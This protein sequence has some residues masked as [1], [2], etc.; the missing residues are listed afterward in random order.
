MYI[1]EN[2]LFSFWTC[3]PKEVL[4]LFHAVPYVLLP[5][6]LSSSLSVSVFTNELSDKKRLLS[7]LL[8][9]YSL[10]LQTL[11]AQWATQCYGN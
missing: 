10:L 3:V 5:T 2:S 7:Q 9:L 11:S 6:Q 8:V 4:H 1:V